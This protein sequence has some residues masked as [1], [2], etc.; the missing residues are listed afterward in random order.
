MKHVVAK[1]KPKKGAANIVHL[2]LVAL[3]PALV[4]VTVRIHV[5]Q[6]GI[7]LIL[8]SKWRMFAV[9]PR[10]WPANIRANIIDIIVGASALV[11]MLQ[12]GSQLWQLIWAVAYGVWLLLIKPQSGVAAVSAQALIGQLLGLTTLLL[13][14]GD[15]PTLVL[16][17]AG[18]GICYS[19]A[20]HF[21]TSFDEPLSRSLAQMWGY[22][23][24]ALMWLAGHW[25]IFYGSIAQPTLLLGVIAFGIASLYYLDETDRLSVLYRRQ[26][27][28]IMVAVVAIIIFLSGWGDKAI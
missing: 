10:H 9:K 4:Y 25:L 14:F 13:R 3:L 18:W 12:S 20:R 8:I 1:I 27:V 7:A 26:I 17:I 2:F 22:F 24:A 11:F 23:G 28:F 21:L 5:P 15:A 6:I 16:V 19:A